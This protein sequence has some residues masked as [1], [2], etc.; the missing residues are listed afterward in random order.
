MSNIGAHPFLKTARPGPGPAQGETPT[1]AE[2]PARS[3]P[4]AAAALLALFGLGVYFG[5]ALLIYLFEAMPLVLVIG[6]CAV[7][8]ANVFAWA[9]GAAAARPWRIEDDDIVV[10]SPL[11]EM[12][13]RR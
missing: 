2:G 5:A 1:A 3:Q 7:I 10:I 8:I 9:L 13:F 11:Y 4:L 12:R 6:G